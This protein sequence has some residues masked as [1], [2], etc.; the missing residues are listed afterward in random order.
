[1]NDALDA[2][3]L[4]ASLCFSRPSYVGLDIVGFRQGK[5]SWTI[6]LQSESILYSLHGTM[7]RTL[8][9]MAQQ[10]ALRESGY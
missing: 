1:M 8:R 9:I 2:R 7:A 5:R 6:E 3:K 4:Y 10:Q